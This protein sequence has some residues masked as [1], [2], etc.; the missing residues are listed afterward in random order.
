MIKQWAQVER[1]SGRTLSKPDLFQEFVL[2]LEQKAEQCT[3]QA[4]EARTEFDRIKLEA[5]L[6]DTSA[7]SHA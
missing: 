4:S 2:L 3:L 1:T 6:P 7:E 5:H